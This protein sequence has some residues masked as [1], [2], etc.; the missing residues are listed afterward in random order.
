MFG[1][2]ATRGGPIIASLCAMFCFGCADETSTGQAKKDGGGADSG[3]VDVVQ[4]S[5]KRTVQQG[6]D[7]PGW[8]KE[9]ATNSS[10]DSL[11][12]E[13]IGPLQAAGVIEDD[14]GGRLIWGEYASEA[15]APREKVQVVFQV[16][17]GSSAGGACVAGKASHNAGGAV[18]KG[19]G[20]A[21]LDHVDIGRAVLQKEAVKG[22]SDGHPTILY[23]PLKQKGLLDPAAT[24]ARFA[25]VSWGKRRLVIVSAY[26]P[27]VGVVATKTRAAALDSGR[28]DSVSEL[29]YARR[30]DVDRLLASMT[31]LDSLVW[32]AAGVIETYKSGKAA[33]GVGMTVSRGVFGD[34]LYHRDYVGDVLDRPPLGGPGLVVLAGSNTLYSD[35]PGQSG[36]FA[37]YLREFP[38]RPVVGFEGVVEAAG[39]DAGAAALIAGLAAGDDLDTAMGAAGK[40][41]GAKA[42]SLLEED[43]RKLWMW[44]LATAKLFTHVP[45]AG[46]LKLHMSINPPICVDISTVGS[47]C[48]AAT[49]D[50]AAKAGKEVDSS[51]LT[52]KHAT[53]RCDPTFQGPFFDC[54][55]KDATLGTDFQVRGVLQGT[56]V[57]AQI[58]VYATGTAGD[59]VQGVAL[60]GVGTIKIADVGGGTTKLLFDGPGLASTFSDDKGR[61][62]IAKKPALSS[63]TSEPSSLTF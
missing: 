28:F 37:S 8:A 44:P 40:A 6:L 48:D 46:K 14:D 49:F 24:A 7:A 36:V 33:K 63:N 25:Q 17:A 1:R 30:V 2:K 56:D 10:L 29:H 23:A 51:L 3:P 42:T 4:S 59:R 20:D 52:A 34:E 22:Q 12:K 27:Q 35:S 11:A 43:A 53:F 13:M 58:A 5:A 50:E 45:K 15:L 21:V 32:L 26:G 62:C 9:L 57:G 38:Y 54:K 39:A 31:P 55:A 18:L 41:S 47:T 61:C 60:I 19:P 16:C